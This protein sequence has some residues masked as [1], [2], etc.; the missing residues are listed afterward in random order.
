MTPQAD[1]DPAQAPLPSHAAVA[2]PL[3]RFHDEAWHTPQGRLVR[4][5]IFGLNDGVISTLGFLAGVTATLDDLRTIVLAGI[6]AAVAGAVSMGMGAFVST[7]SQ[8]A[9][10]RA[11]IAREAWEIEHMPEHERQEIR[12]IYQRLGFAP[13]EVDVIV[14]RVTSNPEL[15]LRVMSR[16]E[17]GL[18][19]ETFDSPVRV[20]AVTS[21]AFLV[22]SAL[23]L[24]PYSFRPSPSGAVTAV[25][26]VAVA[27]L[28][29]TGAAKTWLT[30]EPLLRSSLELAGL[31]MLACV[32]GLL[33][34]RLAGVAV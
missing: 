23:L 27:T 9:F 6:A 30:K 31:G 21:L 32:I 25:A 24:V 17:L 26:G 1:G 8:R 20:G 16:E 22:G 13:E 4:E 33:L 14:R 29:A 11:E 3:K 28:L 10:F 7:K 15:W 18:V 5:I 12:E 2:Q 34:G 19:E